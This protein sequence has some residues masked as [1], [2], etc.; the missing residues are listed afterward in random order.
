MHREVMDVNERRINKLMSEAKKVEKKLEQIKKLKKDICQTQKDSN[1][2][3][4]T[5][6]DFHGKYLAQMSEEQLDQFSK[7]C[8]IIRYADRH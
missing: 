3:N 1:W 2:M 6:S 7:S 4:Y 5:T 8:E